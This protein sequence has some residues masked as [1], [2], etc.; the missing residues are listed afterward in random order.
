MDGASRPVRRLPA[1]V[2]RTLAML[3]VT[4]LIAGCMGPGND[5]DGTNDGAGTG[6]ADENDLFGSLTI[7]IAG[8]DRPEGVDDDP[9]PVTVTFAHIGFLGEDD[10][11]YPVLGEATTVA[12]E[13]TDAVGESV[14]VANVPMVAGTYSDT[15]VLASGA[16]IDDGAGAEDA[17]VA[18]ETC[19]VAGTFTVPPEG[20]TAITLILGGPESFDS[21]GGWS[22]RPALV[23]VLTDHDSGGSFGDAS[24]SAN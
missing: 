1:T 6:E 21:N 16:T 20:T 10:A 23:G 9:V 19:F 12:F 18:D 24:C 13:L 3:L 7:H 11:W 14:M 8:F 15:E 2:N 22:F 4:M 5:A 17:T